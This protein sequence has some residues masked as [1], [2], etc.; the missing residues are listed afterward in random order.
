MRYLHLNNTHD[1]APEVLGSE[2]V[3]LLYATQ[4][5]NSSSAK[6]KIIPSWCAVPE[7]QDVWNHAAHTQHGNRKIQ[8]LTVGKNIYVRINV[9][10][11]DRY[12]IY[13]DFSRKLTE[14]STFSAT[15]LSFKII[16]LV[17]QLNS[18]PQVAHHFKTFQIFTPLPPAHF[19][20]PHH[21]DVITNPRICHGKAGSSDALRWF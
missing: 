8:I 21:R 16:L 7:R 3:R 12:L 11:T 19:W 18:T 9:A 6:H 4:V 1:R 10:K 2:S 5:Q 14:H 17:L 13:L 15:K 20:K